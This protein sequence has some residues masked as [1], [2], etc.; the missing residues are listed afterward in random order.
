[1]TVDEIQKE[2]RE[3]ARIGEFDP[4][5]AHSREDLMFEKVLKAI[6]DGHPDAP[7]LAREAVRSLKSEFSRWC[8]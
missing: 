5:E 4:E 3:I 1:M 6:A 2:A 7:S 8:G